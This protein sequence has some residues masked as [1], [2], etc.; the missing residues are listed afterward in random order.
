MSRFQPDTGWEMALRPLAMA[1]PD[2]HVYVEIM[3]PDLRFV[4]AVAT[5]LGVLLWWS[6]ARLRG[7]IGHSMTEVRFRA[8]GSLLILLSAMFAMWVATTGN[9]RYFVPGLMLIGPV[10]AALVYLLPV[11][12]VLRL[13]VLLGMCAVQGFVV[14]QSDPW[15]AWTMA[16]WSAP[17]YF[18]ID[19]PVD[20]KEQPWTFMTSS[21]ISYS[22]LAP[23][24]HPDS[25]WINLHNAP[26]PAGGSAE[27]ARTARFLLATTPGR[28]QLLVPAVAAEQTEL[29]LPSANVLTALQRQIE[30]FGVQML[31]TPACRLLRST[32]LG[33]IGLGERRAEQLALAGFWACP[34]AR[35]VSAPVDARPSNRPRYDEVFRVIESQCPRFFPSGG[36]DGSVRLHDGEMRSY[37]RGEMKAYVYDNGAVYYKYYRALNPVQVGHVDEIIAGTKRVECKHIQG[38]SGMPWARGI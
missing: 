16:T 11:T 19:I 5:L 14:H 20:L 15:R 13:A 2:A 31:P 9:G 27:S 29:G 26:A 32:T 7:R 37:M 21:A 24:F 23:Q 1:A 10:C 25:R 6:W 8:I 3:A 12:R 4:F 18:Q 33:Q 35:T 30:K 28:I 34:L 36:D 38:R 22:L 17:P